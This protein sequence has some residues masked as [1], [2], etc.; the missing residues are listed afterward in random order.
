MPVNPPLVEA[1]ERLLHCTK[2]R[3]APL[4]HLPYVDG[5]ARYLAQVAA[6]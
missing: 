3:Q 1:R 5:P 2:V 4:V 6:L